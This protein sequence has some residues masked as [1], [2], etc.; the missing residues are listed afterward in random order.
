MDP[1]KILKIQNYC[2]DE[3]IIKNAWKKYSIKYHPDKKGKLTKKFILVQEAYKILNER[4]RLTTPIIDKPSE[5]LE[6]PEYKTNN[7]L[8][9]SK[10]RSKTRSKTKPEIIDEAISRQDWEDHVKTFTKK[11]E[12]GV[13][14]KDV[15]KYGRTNINLSS[16]NSKFEQ[17]QKDYHIVSHK[18]FIPVECQTSLN[19][20]ILGEDSDRE[21]DREEN[22]NLLSDEENSEDEKKKI[23]TNDIENDAWLWT[24]SMAPNPS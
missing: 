1:Y 16:F 20:V 7:L 24:K 8:T 14:I 11:R 12:K 17:L 2:T 9:V 6:K 21:S 4:I 23:N 3:A 18:P 10:T 13:K 22:N 15:F 5:K 19:Y